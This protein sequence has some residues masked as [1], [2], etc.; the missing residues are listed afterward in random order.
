MLKKLLKKTDAVLENNIFPNP[1]I[2]KDDVINNS[3]SPV[4]NMVEGNLHG[5]PQNLHALI[6]NEALLNKLVSLI[7]PQLLLELEK[8]YGFEPT[9]KYQIEVENRK[10]YIN[11]L[12]A[13][14]QERKQINQTV[15][16]ELQQFLNNTT[17]SLTKAL[18]SFS[19]SVS[20]RIRDAETKHGIDTVKDA[21]LKDTTAS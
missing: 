10:K 7:T 19:H 11:Q 21:L 18:E 15:E 5:L 14:L 6:N 16:N 9:D 20:Q 8:K 2:L 1:G 13:Y 12:D 17:H 4:P 3:N